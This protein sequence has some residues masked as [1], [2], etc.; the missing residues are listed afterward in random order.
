MNMKTTILI[1]SFCMP[2]FSLAQTNL[3]SNPSFEGDFSTAV[4]N[5]GEPFYSNPPAD[6]FEYKVSNSADDERWITDSVALST[7]PNL[8]VGPWTNAYFNNLCNANQTAFDSTDKSLMRAATGRFFVGFNHSNDG[9][10]EGFQ[11][12]LGCDLNSGDYQFKV[13]W[14]RAFPC[15]TVKFFVHL[16]R[17]YDS[18]HSKVLENS[19]SGSS[20][21]PGQW[22]TE[23]KNFTINLNQNKWRELDWLVVT[24]G[25]GIGN[26]NWNRYLYF[27][28]ISLTR[29]CDDDSACFVPTGQICPVFATPGP[30]GPPMVIKNIHNA[31]QI[32]VIIYNQLVQTLIDTTF[33]NPNG[34]PE[35]YFQPE[36]LSGNVASGNYPYE[37]TIFNKCGGVKYEGQFQVQAGIYDTLGPWIDSTAHWSEVPKE[38]CL[39]T[40][41]LSNMEIV[42][43][44]SYIVKDTIWIR[45]GVTAAGNSNILIQAG[46]V[47]EMDSVEFDGTNSVVEILEAPCQGCR[48]A[49][50]PSGGTLADMSEIGTNAILTGFRPEPKGYAN[51]NST[52]GASMNQYA[53]TVSDQESDFQINLVAY[54]N[55]FSNTLNLEIELPHSGPISLTVYDLYMRAV[56]Q[57]FDDKEM[58]E[59]IHPISL[60]LSRI[61]VGI[62]FVQILAEGQTRTEKVIKQ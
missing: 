36:I 27:D 10:R 60:D 40:L 54:P 41:T 31:N 26:N 56:T 33:F 23:T 18:R 20:F 43:D 59:G 45:D 61:P 24:G 21:Q 28:D 35:L 52:M 44:V 8:I 5:E 1:L 7:N 16:S 39:H 11:Q 55:P 6:W 62:Y 15:E 17:D 25:A 48:L 14:A 37:V 58:E 34:L 29:P 47:V 57:I 30:P 38:C 12:Y 51:E 3:L 9:T 50:A 49:P 19:I 4:P 22:Y 2:F 53:P 46:Q 42:G 13:D 32:H